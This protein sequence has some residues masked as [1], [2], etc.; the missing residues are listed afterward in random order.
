MRG[1]LLAI[2]VF[3]VSTVA[4]GDEIGLTTTGVGILTIPTGSEWIN[5]TIQCW[6]GGG[7]GGGCYYGYGGG[8]GGGG[9][10]ACN[11]YT[12]LS[13]GAYN[14]YIGSGGEGGA[15]GT[16]GY[17][18]DTGGGTIWNY[19][20][21]EDVYATGGSGGSGGGIGGFGTGGNAGLVLAGSGY[22]GGAGGI[23]DSHT[24]G[25]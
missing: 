21:S 20:G 3:L 4:Y 17:A 6:G 5:V 15:G 16:T 18:G 12:S 10:Y 9:A 13:S 24:N 23:E 11:T 8:G 2:A 19:G 14:Y 7:G 25:Y 1:M 22:Q